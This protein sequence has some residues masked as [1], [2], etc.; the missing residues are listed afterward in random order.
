MLK[1][2]LKETPAYYLFR[3]WQ[4]HW[5]F[6]RWNRSWAKGKSVGVPALA[7]PPRLFKQLLVSRYAAIYDSATFIETGTFLG[8]MLYAQRRNFHRLISFEIDHALYLRAQQR[9]SR[10]SRVNLLHG[11]STFLL[12][13]VLPNLQEPCLF[14]L[15][16]HAMG[17][18]QRRK[19]PTPPILEELEAILSSDLQDCVVLVDDARLFVEQS[20]FPSLEKVKETVLHY[21]PHW[22]FEVRNDVIRTHPPDDGITTPSNSPTP[23]PGHRRCD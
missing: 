15:D 21:R 7:T 12:P 6:L 1:S 5:E 10:T 8:D 19:Y 18:A 14:W 23:P 20:P 16:A 11:D 4:A 17:A 3:R 22:Q 9:F 13:Q 2:R